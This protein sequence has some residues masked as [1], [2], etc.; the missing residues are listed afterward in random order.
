[1]FLQHRAARGAF[2]PLAGER[3]GV[4]SYDRLAGLPLAVD[5]VGHCRHERDT[6]S[7][8]VRVTTTLELRGDGAVGRGEDVTYEADAHDGPPVDPDALPAGADTFGAF[9]AALDDLS[10]FEDPPSDH[11]PNFRRWAVESAALD[12]ALAQ[13][14]EHLASALAVDPAPA[15]YVV[16]TRL[17]EAGF[18]RI[19]DVLAVLPDA[20]FKLDPTPDWDDA[21][22]ARLADTG[23]VRTLDLKGYYEG[24]EVDVE[25]DA[26]FYRRV[27]DAFPD[28]VIE[29]AAVTPETRPVLAEERERLAWDYPVTGVESVEALPFEPRWLNVKP[30]RFGSVESVL[31]TVDW[32]RERDVAL[33]G[34]GQFELGPG[35]GQIQALA[36]TLYPDAPNDVAPGAVNDPEPPADLPASPLAVPDCWT[37]LGW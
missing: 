7:G 8:F 20:E 21:L 2:K 30:S 18:D 22:L 26:D 37:G 17:G 28:A 27:L 4:T 19:E 23:R 32:A 34:G 5:G 6:S 31:A 15:R 36:A 9:A 10:L 35:R 11:A 16:S 12:L 14:G 1:V 25:P 13:A 3:A 29:D 24:T 33:Y